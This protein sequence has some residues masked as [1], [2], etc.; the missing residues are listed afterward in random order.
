MDVQLSFSKKRLSA[1][2]MDHII[3]TMTAMVF[4]IPGMIYLFMNFNNL[5]YKELVASADMKIFTYWGLIGIA[6]YFCKDCIWGQSIAKRLLKL[7][8][9]NNK[10]GEIAGPFRCLVR[11][12]FIVVFPVEGLMILVNPSKRLGDLVA[13]TKLIPFDPSIKLVDIKLFQCFCAF[14]LAYFFAFILMRITT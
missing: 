7:Q 9:V 10:T 13:G 11:N 12:L 6:F 2:I 8:I 3:M 1:A 14:L 5:S 4:F